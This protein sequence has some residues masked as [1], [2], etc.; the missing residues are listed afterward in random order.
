[1]EEIMARF[2]LLVSGLFVIVD[3]VGSIPLMLGLTNEHSPGAKRA[4]ILRACLFAAGLLI[5]FSLVGARALSLLHINLDAF[6]IAG[7]ALLFLTAIEMMRSGS[8]RPASETGGAQSF[9]DVSYVPLG[10]PSL[11]GPGAITS[12]IVFSTDHVHAHGWHALLII[13][14]IVLVFVASYFILR[15]SVGIQRLFGANGLMVL[16]RVMGLFLAALAVQ[17][18]LEGA[19][20]LAGQLAGK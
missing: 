17:F 13:S 4:V 12:V 8:R 14:A 5:F 19:L 7:G 18:V 15:V 11:A 20:K 1:M 3:P 6:R 16:S 9:A 2:A 10:M